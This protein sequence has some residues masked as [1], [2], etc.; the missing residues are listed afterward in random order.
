MHAVLA[1]IAGGGTWYPTSQDVGSSPTLINAGN[2]SAMAANQS[3][4]RVKHPATKY[5]PFSQD[6]SLC[7]A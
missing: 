2:Q 7:G 6:Q 5:A 4:R 3:A 1:T